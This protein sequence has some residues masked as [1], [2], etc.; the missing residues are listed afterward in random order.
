MSAI[1]Q[2]TYR[3]RFPE[4]I[5]ATHQKWYK[6]H[7]KEWRIKHEYG[8]TLKQYYDRLQN[9]NNRC[10]ICYTTA[11]GNNYKAM[12]YFQIDHDHKSGLIRGLLCNTC[13]RALGLF[14][15]DAEICERASIYLKGE[16]K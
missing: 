4:R 5:K 15:D 13:N 11:P 16:G 12:R 10:K 6:K 9:Q 14:K 1:A 8:I 3:T 7:G 2:R